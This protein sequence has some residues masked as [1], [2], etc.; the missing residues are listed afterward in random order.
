MGADAAWQDPDQIKR[1]LYDK[2]RDALAKE[3]RRPV[4]LVV[5]KDKHRMGSIYTSMYGETWTADV[6]LVDLTGANAN[7]YLE[8]G[9]RWA[10][11][12]GVTVLLAQ[13]PSKLPFNVVAARAQPYSND[14]DDLDIS[15]ERIVRSVVEG[16]A[17]KTRGETDSPVRESGKIVSI[18][19]DELNRLKLDLQRLQ[20]ERG[21][22]YMQS[23]ALATSLSTRIELLRHAVRVNPVVAQ[24]RFLLGQALREAG[25]ADAAVGELAKA[26]QLSPGT[27]Q[28]WRELGVALNKMGKPDEAVPALERCLELDPV[29]FEALSVLGG[30]KRRLALDGGPDAVSWELLREARDLYARALTIAPRDTYP[31]LNV[32]RL[33]LLLSRVDPGRKT[34]A[35]ALFRK[36]VPLCEFE[37]Q[38]AKDRAEH[39]S[40]DLDSVIEASYKAFDYAD[41]MLY[42]GQVDAGLAAFR[43]AIDFVRADMQVDIFRSVAAGLDSIL[44]LVDLDE[45]ISEA[46]ASVR[47]M[48][49]VATSRG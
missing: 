15:I 12:D 23:A 20:E 11:S 33:D 30:A 26:T 40:G 8:L 2:V 42:S 3:L 7:V 44:E 17:A 45:P 14:L 35:H 25:E 46:I 32:A 9:V 21:E 18:R 49:A 5:E 6:Y 48:L 4:E 19:S 43:D 1:R 10:M 36:T 41:C 13:D 37:L 29:D 34:A 38:D 22:G 47:S 27:P 39:D 28:Y 31:L 16:L 24:S